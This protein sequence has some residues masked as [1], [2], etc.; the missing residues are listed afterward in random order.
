[1]YRCWRQQFLPK[2]WPPRT[3]IYEA[4][5][6]TASPPDSATYPRVA[7]SPRLAQPPRYQTQSHTRRPNPISSKYAD[8][9]KYIAIAESNS[10]THPITGQAQKCRHLM[11]GDEK[12]IWKNPSPTSSADLHKVLATE[13]M[14]LTPSSSNKNLRYRET[15]K[16]LM[17]VSFVTSRN[18]KPKLIE[19]D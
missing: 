6:I 9:E 12:E 15:K 10:V 16:W 18:T 17:D 19:H 7:P 11:K 2:Q 14:A 1:M 8:A 13:F 3:R 4:W 5:A